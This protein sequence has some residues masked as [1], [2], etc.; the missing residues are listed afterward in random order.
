[1]PMT[2]PL[3]GFT[4]NNL[5]GQI[6]LTIELCE[7]PIGFQD[8]KNFLI[9]DNKFIYNGILESPALKQM[10]VVTSVYHLCMKFETPK[11]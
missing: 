8:F 10:K 6:M 11:G 2:E 1:M 5:G 3:Y 9:V 4:E 7:K